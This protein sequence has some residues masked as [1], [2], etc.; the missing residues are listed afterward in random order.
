[1]TGKLIFRIVFYSP[2]KK[3]KGKRR[4]VAVDDSDEEGEDF[5]IASN[6]GVESDN[7]TDEVNSKEIFTAHVQSTREGNVF[8]LSVSQGWGGSGGTLARTGTG[9]AAGYASC[10]QAG[11]PSCSLSEYFHLSAHFS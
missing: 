2:P 5:E 8:T 10:G 1:M 6:T 4:R 11:G 3:Q 7:D 9:Y